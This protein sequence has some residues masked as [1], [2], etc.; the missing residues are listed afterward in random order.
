[1]PYCVGF[2]ERPLLSLLLDASGAS[3]MPALSRGSP[4]PR[5]WLPSLSDALHTPPTLQLS[6]QPPSGLHRASSLALVI[7]WPCAAR[8]RAPLHKLS[9]RCAQEG[10]L[11]RDVSPQEG[12]EPVSKG[13]E[14]F[15]VSSANPYLEA[16][17]RLLIRPSPR[18]P[19]A[20]TQQSSRREWKAFCFLQTSLK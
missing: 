5:G 2:A 10:P 11:R 6:S 20:V 19:Q 13:S 18:P 14:R 3:W 4:E 9:P 12:E 8:P 7:S 17:V 1:M 16:L 15:W